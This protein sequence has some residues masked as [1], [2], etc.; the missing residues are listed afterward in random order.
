V[1]EPEP[2]LPSDT[3]TANQRP[4]V[5]P[6]PDAAASSDHPAAESNAVP[7]PEAAAPSAGEAPPADSASRPPAGDE[8]DDY[9]ILTPELVEE[10]AI[11]GDFVLRWAVV[12]LALLLGSTRI[13]ETTTLVH[14][15]TGQY[16]A[17]H[18]IL[19]PAH[20]VFSYTAADRP[21]TNLSWGFDLLAAGVYALGSFAGLSV[22]K[23]LMIALAFWLIGSISLRGAPTWW[24]SVCAGTA[25]MGCHLR[26][27]AEP[28]IITFVGMGL[29][30]LLL[31]HWREAAGSAEPPP[32]ETK[33]LWLLVPLFLVWS[34]LDTRAWL[35]PALILFYAAGDSLG[36]WLL[37]PNTLNRAARKQLWSV[38]GVSVAATLVHPFGW[39]SLAAPWFTYT[40]EYPA[41]RDY[42]S[43]AY[44]GLDEPPEP[45]AIPFFP[46]TTPAFWTHLDTASI[47]ALLVLA[48]ALAT[49]IL[50]RRR[51]DWGHLAMFL[52]FALLAVA[53]IR[54]LPAAAIVGGVLATLN[55]QAWYMA[56]CRRTYS[57]DSWELLYSRGGRAATVLV[58]AV[59]AFFS[60]TGRLRDATAA[61]GRS[62][63]GID[64]NLELQLSDLRQQL[65]GDAS[66]DHRPFNLWLTQGN[67]L[68]WIDERVFADSR[69][70]VY[71]APADE[72]NLLA[73][74]LLARDALRIRRDPDTGR[75]EEPRRSVWG[76]TFEHYDVTH[77]VVRLTGSDEEYRT[78]LDLAQDV[79]HWVWTNLGATT[80]VFYRG[81]LEREGDLR[82]F[83]TAQAID[84]RKQAYREQPGDEAKLDLISRDRWIR[85]PSFYQKYF[86]SSRHD[87]PAEIHEGRH[88][89][90]LAS[91]P[92]VLLRA[93]A[94]LGMAYLAVRKAQSGLTKDPDA[95]AGY[96]VLGQAYD[97]IAQLESLVATNGSRPPRTG[98]RYLQTVAAYNQALV[99]DPQ[100]IVVQKAL[101][102]IYLEAQKYDLALRHLEACDEILSANAD[103]NE[104]ELLQIGDQLGEL[105]KRMQV[106]EDDMA[107]FKTAESNPVNLAQGYMQRACP[108]KALK[109]LDRG[110]AQAQVTPDIR[111]RVQLQRIMLLIETG[112]VDEAYTAAS[113]LA[114]EADRLGIPK[115]DWTDVVALA[116][117]TFADYSGAVERWRAAADEAEKLSIN[118]LLLSLA[119]QAPWP[120]TAVGSSM[121][122]LFQ[123][124]ETI[125]N[126]RVNVALTYLEAGHLAL[127]RRFFEEALDTSLETSARPLIAFFVYELTEGK[128]IIDTLPPSNRVFESFTPEPG[129]EEE[130]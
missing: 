59:L 128:E 22:F 7:A 90:L 49:F 103:Q 84:F 105:K 42:L 118:A 65:A 63:F 71:F 31:Y 5:E 82:E 36:A 97:L 67:Q 46:M 79:R 130:K 87:T 28:A 98:M 44:L 30:L 54:E 33:R 56:A 95:V 80:A 115:S 129:D 89:V 51:L 126:T 9:E 32:A 23:A 78:F 47:A 50:N 123:Q 18:G 125:A 27:T 85:P 52:G 127:A 17:S 24:G 14:V 73:Q 8:F 20:D 29:T 12:L 25:L 124:P 26:L 21:W 2:A 122:F 108:L 10:E 39:K 68:I 38:A 112:R 3:S 62:G 70:G 104:K 48:A 41:F 120:L 13:A 66:F 107:Q 91:S 61:R 109:E 19:P 83:V 72:D 16:L 34:N 77:V 96:V 99:G 93:D 116:N 113:L 45:F 119:P 35:G 114:E 57:V 92:Q 106:V 4:L 121:N 117:L 64:H 102:Q 15:K 60:G 86:W 6:R 37:S 88:L 69:V 101:V 1:P 53:A 100:N 76:K 75:V 94:R 43:K 58:F 81:D 74:H 55:G 40:V 110:L 111:F 11:R